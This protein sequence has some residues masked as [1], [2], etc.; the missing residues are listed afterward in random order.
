MNT[1]PKYFFELEIVKKPYFSSNTPYNSYDLHISTL[2]HD[3]MLAFE[4][5]IEATT[6]NALA[7][8]YTEKQDLD[9]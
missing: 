4:S 1:A 3:Y 7:F 6:A 2:T 8:G 5:H 9:E